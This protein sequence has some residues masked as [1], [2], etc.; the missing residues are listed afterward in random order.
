MVFNNLK[1]D[2]IFV[3]DINLE[4]SQLSI[5]YSLVAKNNDKFNDKKNKNKNSRK[6]FVSKSNTKKFGNSE[7]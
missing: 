7:N 4:R 5:D 2:T 6:K 3:L 1:Y